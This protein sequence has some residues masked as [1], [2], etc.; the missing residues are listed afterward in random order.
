MGGRARPMD[1]DWVRQLRDQSLS[2]G[3][4]FFLKQ[5]GGS[6]GKR[7]GGEALIDNRTWHHR[8]LAQTL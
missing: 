7:G 4:A 3:V 1:L 6:R 8:P 5:L 2:A